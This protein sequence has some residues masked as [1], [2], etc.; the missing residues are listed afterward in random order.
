MTFNLAAFGLY[1]TGTI[2]D[3]LASQ[4]LL[5]KNRFFR[6]RVWLARLNNRLVPVR[7]RPNAARLKVKHYVS[8]HLAQTDW[9]VWL[10]I[11]D[12]DKG[13]I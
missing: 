5:R 9:K 11:L 13:V 2:M 10:A 4:T 3:S 8:V 6:R 12:I 1:L 7:Y